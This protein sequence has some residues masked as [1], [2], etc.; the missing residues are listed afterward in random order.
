[1]QNNQRTVNVDGTDYMITHFKTSQGLGIKA[2]LIKIAAPL[3]ASAN[4]DKEQEI[5][6][7]SMALAITNSLDRG[8]IVTLCKELVSCTYK[9]SQQI[10]FDLEFM[11]RYDVLFN[12]V[13]E[14]LDF[15]YSS[16]F[17]ALGTHTA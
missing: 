6:I 3:I 1:M 11:G 14:V 15:N 16:V 7:Q 8:E 13:K 5:N 4:G 12:L 9:G 2:Q 10:N 17:R